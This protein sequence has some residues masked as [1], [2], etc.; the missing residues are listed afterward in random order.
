MIKIDAWDSDAYEA[1]SYMQGIVVDRVLSQHQFEKHTHILDLGCGDGKNT[2]KIAKQV[3]PGNVLGVDSSIR[4]IESAK[5]RYADQ[6]N[7]SFIHG[8]IATLDYN[9]KFDFIVSFFCLD[10]IKDQLALQMRIRRAFKSNGK[11]LYVISTGKDECAEIV[12]KVAQSDK[13]KKF[14]EGYDIPAGLH[15][16]EN[17]RNSLQQASFII[18]YFEVMQIPVELPNIDMFKKFITALPLFGQQLTEVQTVE[19][20]DDITQEFQIHCD[21]KYDGKLICSGEILVIKAHV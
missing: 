3:A 10:W 16:I 15:P 18:D 14:L 12:E 2:I 4:Q 1:G 8:D 13:W 17:Y 9:E 11:L 20:I 19:I 21:L 6:K 5:T 7:L